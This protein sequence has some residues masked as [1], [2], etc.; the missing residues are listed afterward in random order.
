MARSRSRGGGTRRVRVVQFLDLNEYMY[1]QVLRG[2]FFRQVD[3]GDPEVDFNIIGH[4]DT[5]VFLNPDKN[6][7]LLGGD[8]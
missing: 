6:V 1:E 8:K 5:Y 2:G 3:P 4:E 7:F